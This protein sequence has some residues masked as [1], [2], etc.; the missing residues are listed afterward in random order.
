MTRTHLITGAGSGIGEALTSSLVDRGEEVVL[1]ARSAE[2]ADD[3]RAGFPGAMVLVGDLAD[4]ESLEPLAASLPDRLDSLIHVAGV[5]ELGPVAELS[6]SDL[7]NHLEVNLIGPAVL[8]KIALP[9]LRSSG[10][11]VV[12]VNSGAGLRAKS[13]WSA[14]AASKFGLRALAD[15]LR[16][17]ERDNGLRVTTV[18]PSRTATPMQEKVH[19]QE[20][21]RYD[22]ASWIRPQSVADTILHVLDL[23]VDAT[24]PEVEVGVGPGHDL[25]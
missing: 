17:E 24:I 11:L 13:Q 10:G 19:G 6:A 9:A 14:Y 25:R 7:R 22:A 23:P 8:T 15:S 20:G 18:F 2:R 21:K 4:P 12:F 5:V 1:L 16:D 3:L